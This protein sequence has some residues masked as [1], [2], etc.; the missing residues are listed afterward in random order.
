MEKE[1]PRPYKVGRTGRKLFYTPEGKRRG[2]KFGVSPEKQYS[3][4]KE[5]LKASAEK[6][7]EKSGGGKSY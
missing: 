7:K 4:Y 5:T 3:L 6:E 1:D 2:K